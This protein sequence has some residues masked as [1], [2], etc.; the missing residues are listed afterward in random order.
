MNSPE[1]Y[2]AALALWRERQR[3]QTETNQTEIEIE[4]R[5]HDSDRVL[6]SS[7]S[8]SVSP[9]C[10]VIELFGVARLKAKT[11]RVT[12]SLSAEAKIT[13]ALVALAQACPELVGTVISLDFH[14]LLPGYACNLNGIE[15]VRA[16]DSAIQN[17]DHLLI[18]SSDAGG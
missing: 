16:F 15:F 17:G 9:L 12:L 7:V 14:S 4:K 6:P 13:D 2:Q 11:E 1:D 3:T 10:L 5:D 8:V 18:L